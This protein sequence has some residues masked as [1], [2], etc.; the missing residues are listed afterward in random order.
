VG[1]L[2]QYSIDDFELMKII[3]SGSYATVLMVEH[4]KSQCIYAMKVIEKECAAKNSVIN[5]F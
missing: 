1:V 5:I 3:G 2:C 4:K